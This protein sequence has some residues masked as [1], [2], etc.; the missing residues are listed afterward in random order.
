MLVSPQLLAVIALGIAVATWAVY[1]VAIAKNTLSGLPWTSMALMLAALGGGALAI[2]W[3]PTAPVIVPAAVGI[4]MSGLF[5]W[6]L[7]VRKTPVGEINVSVG[8]TLLPFAAQRGDGSQF[9]SDSLAGQ[10]VLLKFFRGSW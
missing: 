3:Q 1:L 4:T 7:S 2:A 9:Q 10:R 5:L 8:D 6:L